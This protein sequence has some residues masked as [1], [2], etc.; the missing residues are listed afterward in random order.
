MNREQITAGHRARLANVYIRQSSAHQ[1]LHHQESQRRQRSL[2]ERAIELGWP[3]ELVVQIDEDLGVSASVHQQRLAFN[4]MVVEVALGKIGIILALEVSRLSRANQDWYH[5]LDICSVTNTLI[6]DAEGLYDPRAY[7]DRLLLGLKGTM[8]E[9]ELHVMKQRLV[10]AMREKAK[11]GEF[12]FCLPPGF[13]WDE[14]GRIQK[15]PDE[16]VVSAIEFIFQ[17]FD[18][19]GTVHQTQ[20][21]LCEENRRVPV[22]AGRNRIEWKL[23]SYQYVHRVLTNPMYAGAYAYGQRRTE[24]KL[25]E[26]LRPVKRIRKVPRKDWHALIKDH[27]PGYVSWEVYEK[28]QQRIVEN[29]RGE[30]ASGAPREGDSLLQGL[31]L[32]GRCGGRMKVAYGKRSML[33]YRCVR[34]RDQKGAPVCQAFGAIRLERAVE[35]LVLE[36]LEPAGI[37]AMMEAARASAAE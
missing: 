8:S 26:S 12:R 32:C 18:E 15:T 9:A 21:S 7:N 1:V 11:R 10:E 23:P 34:Q 14:A 20:C 30:S 28:N 5:L 24:E 6:A 27:H 33:R 22:R 4:D 37:E 17:R 36:C 35:A 13:L 31:V 25:D 3:R 29:R 2:V 16:Q 19:L